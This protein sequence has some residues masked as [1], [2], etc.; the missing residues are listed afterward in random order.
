MHC[1][2]A[3]KYC[4]PE[5]LVYTWLPSRKLDGDFFARADVKHS[6]FAGYFACR[7]VANTH[8]VSPD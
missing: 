4:D 2:G 3:A 6:R 1:P 8:F 5:P 7:F